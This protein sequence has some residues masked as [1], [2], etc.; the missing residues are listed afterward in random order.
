M[1]TQETLA[2]VLSL[3]NLRSWAK[4]KPDGAYVGE[5]ESAEYCPLARFLDE[6]TERT[7]NVDQGMAIP[8]WSFV[9]DTRDAYPLPT[10]ANIVVGMVDALPGMRV[11]REQF[12]QILDEIALKCDEKGN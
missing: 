10:W 8:R 12:L 2:N 4:D 7:W 9:E 6:N 3:D 1:N 5:P 11:K